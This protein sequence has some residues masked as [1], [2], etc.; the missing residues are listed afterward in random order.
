MDKT[1]LSRPMNPQEQLCGKYSIGRYAWLLK[2]IRPL[3]SP[4]PAKEMLGLWEAGELPEQ[5]ALFPFITRSY[6][7]W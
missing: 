6:K 2:E 4:L 1:F 7:P 5:Q 3:A